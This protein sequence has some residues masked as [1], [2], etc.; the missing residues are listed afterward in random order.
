MIADE[1]LILVRWAFAILAGVAF[2][3]RRRHKQESMGYLFVLIGLLV[4]LYLYDGSDVS[5]RV[6]AEWTARVAMMG[7]YWAA[8]ANWRALRSGS[9]VR[10]Q[11]S[12]QER[13]QRD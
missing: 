9:A 10:K 11:V 7:G 3:L 6:A 2:F 13:H 8:Y 4:S 12:T 5:R 1:M